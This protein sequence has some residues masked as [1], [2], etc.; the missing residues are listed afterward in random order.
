MY[1]KITLFIIIS[2]LSIAT[3]AQNRMT[4][5]LLWDLKRVGNIQIS[6]DNSTILFSIKT[7]D[8]NE[9]EGENN[10]Y[11][12]PVDGGEIKKITNFKGGKYDAKWRPDGKKIAF[13]K[14]SN[15]VMNIFEM[16]IDGTALTQI[17]RFKHSIGGFKYSNDGTKILFIRDVKLNKHHSTELESDLTKSNALMRNC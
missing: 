13:M 1:K 6:P 5:E 10:L 2:V 15:D 3:Y 9:N 4:P 14:I 17:S 7:Y 11:T 8:L 16:N 12:I